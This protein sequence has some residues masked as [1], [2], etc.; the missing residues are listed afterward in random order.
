MANVDASSDA[1]SFV[2]RLSAF[3]VLELWSY[4]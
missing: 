2:F 4:G 1:A 3:G